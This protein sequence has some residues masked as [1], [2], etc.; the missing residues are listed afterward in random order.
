MKKGAIIF[1]HNSRKV[2]YSLMAL[3]SGGLVKKHLKVP[4]SLITD[5]STVDWMKSNSSFDIAEDIFENIIFTD[6][7]DTDNYRTLSDGNL[8]DSVPFV[9]G[10]RFSVYDLTPY[11]RT[12]LIDS[13]FLVFSDRLS[14]YLDSDKEFMIAGSMGDLGGDRVGTLDKY[15]SDTGPNL[16]WATNVIFTKNENT[17]TFF[18][19]VDFIKENYSYYCDLFRFYPKPY[20]NDIS[21]SIAKHILDGYSTDLENSLPP[22]PTTTDKDMLINVDDK[23]KLIFLINQ[24]ANDEYVAMSIKDQDVHVMNKQSIVRNSEALLKLI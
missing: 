15:V 14:A 5:Q 19:L 24:G 12:L 6:R 20:R 7:P 9:N 2:D 16:Y 13:D 21:F 18:N 4:V 11:D 8:I 17:K 3:I 23:G 22:V 10:N 1:A